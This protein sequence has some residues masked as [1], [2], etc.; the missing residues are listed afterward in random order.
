M[1]KRAPARRR[2]RKAEPRTKGVDAGEYRL[3][4]TTG[5]VAAAI[6]KAGGWV[7]SSAKV[8]LVNF[9]RRRAYLPVSS[10]TS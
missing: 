6:E 2:P 10:V 5:S 3:E 9:E 8:G 1:V 4:Q 7:R